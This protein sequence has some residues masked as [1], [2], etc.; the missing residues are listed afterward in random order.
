MFKRLLHSKTL[1]RRTQ[2]ILALVMVPPFIFFFHLWVGGGSAPGPGGMAGK[3][4]G[5]SVPWE[6]FHAE[7]QLVSQYLSEQLGQAPPEAFEPFLRQQAWDRLIIREEARR[8]IRITDEELARFLQAQ[9]TFQQDGRFVP[10]LYDRYVRGLGISV[11]AF[12]ERMRDDLRVQRLVDSVTS[13][14]PLTEEELTAAYAK[15]YERMQ[16]ALIVVEFEALEG[17]VR[18]M[19]TDQALL[20]YYEANHEAVRIPAQRR[21]EYLGRS[22]TEVSPPASAIS[23]ADIQAYYEEHVEEFTRADGTTAAL[24]E[25]REPIRLRRSEELGRESLMELALDLQEDVEAGLRFDEMAAS[26]ALPIR[27]VGPLDPLTADIP[28]GPEGFILRR[29]FEVPLGEMT[30][31]VEASSGVFVLRP[32]EEVPSRLPALEEVRTHLE[33]QFLTEHAREAARAR[34]QQLH[35]E[36]AALLE[37]GATMDQACQVLGITPRRPAPFTRHGSIDSLGSVP[38]LT[39]ALVGLKAGELSE[40]VMIEKGFAFGA[41]EERLP[42]DE[43]EFAMNKEAFRKT[44][45][46]AKEQEQLSTW[47][48][49][50]RAR[51]RLHSFLDEQPQ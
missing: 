29:V 9:Q 35:N 46:A 27:S 1:R 4:F 5:R 17:H 38:S 20:A 25:V 30:E 22:L 50:L 24:D 7:Y 19:L 10:E 42:Y 11:E 8:T 21:I 51:A 43:G 45:Q 18:Q 2:L 28:N 44:L 37:G 13:Q 34:A 40:V 39:Q 14:T 3:V 41:I 23:D 49:A 12:E 6:V 33:R 32:I 26:R 15:D 16:A 31:V 36:L 47:L 48:E